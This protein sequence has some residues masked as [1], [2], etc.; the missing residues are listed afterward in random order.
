M[1]SNPSHPAVASSLSRVT[2][3]SDRFEGV[4]ELGRR[5]VAELGLSD[6]TD[7][8]GRW[9][10]HHLAGLIDDAAK[11][12]QEDRPAKEGRIRDAI[13]ELWARRAEMPDGSRPFQELEPILRAL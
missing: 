1:K 8:L 2:E 3:R 13:L 6:S 5:L 9:M 11:A 7:T 10:A 4:L 12:T